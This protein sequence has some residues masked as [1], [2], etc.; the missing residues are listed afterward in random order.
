[1]LQQ[2][3]TKDHVKSVYSREELLAVQTKGQPHGGR[4]PLSQ[5]AKK[6]LEKRGV[7]TH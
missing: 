6:L 5:G 4:T 1:M 3:L 2:Y 7:N